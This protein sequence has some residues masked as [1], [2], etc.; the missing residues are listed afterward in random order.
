MRGDR[1]Q[2]EIGKFADGLNAGGSKPH[3]PG[4]ALDRPR[5]GCVHRARPAANDVRMRSIADALRMAAENAVYSAAFPRPR[6][7]G[8]FGE[9]E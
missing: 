8:R 2:A 9:E 1:T 7:I 6:R 4:A 3:A 5:L